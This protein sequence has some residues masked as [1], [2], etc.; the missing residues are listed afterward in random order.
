MQDD[1]T[2]PDGQVVGINLNNFE[3]I[4]RDFAMK[5]LLEDRTQNSVGGALFVREFGKTSSHYTNMTFLPNYLR[6][7]REFLPTNRTQDIERASELCGDSYQ[8]R[9]DYG[10][11]LDREM[12]YFTKNYYSSAMTI[13]QTNAE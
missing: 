10:M 3:S 6:D 4:H 12:A 5:W 11:S 2:L 7:P 13:K 9:F 8:C 1:L